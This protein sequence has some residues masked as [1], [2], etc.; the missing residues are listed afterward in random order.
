MQNSEFRIANAEWHRVPWANLFARVALAFIWVP[1]LLADQIDVGDQHFP[2]G[3]VV[4]FEEGRIVFRA[5]SGQVVR[6]AIAE[7]SRIFVDSVGGLDDFNAAEQFTGRDQPAQALPRY[8]RSVRVVDGFWTALIRSRLLLTYDR[9]GRVDK[10]VQ[11]FIKVIEG[12][13]NGPV[14]AAQLMPDNLPTRATAEFRL[15]V[16]QLDAAVDRIKLE[17]HRALVMLMRY[18]LL[19]RANNRRAA[20]LAPAIA[21]LRL[22]ETV[23][24]PRTCRIQYAAL[25]RVFESAPTKDGFQWL[26]QAIRDSVDGIVP[27]LLLLKG[28]SLLRGGATREEFVRAGWAFMRVVIHF[29]D[30]PRAAEGLLGAAAAYERIGRSDKAVRLLEECVA[31]ERAAPAVVKRARAKLERLRSAGENG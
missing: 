14:A 18:A 27:D 29:A 15:A 31:H 26:D 12:R 8:E 9:L 17:D 16:R 20:V 10:A 23:R 3:K 28:R 19:A 7:V 11:N 2:R 6:V 13:W 22:P 25:A 1:P 21:R 4:G 5:S 24:A 30:D